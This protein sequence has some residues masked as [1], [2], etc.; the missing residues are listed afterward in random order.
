[1]IAAPGRGWLGMADAAGD[2]GGYGESHK[3]SGV[4]VLERLIVYSYK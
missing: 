2:T 4:A 1:M 3:S